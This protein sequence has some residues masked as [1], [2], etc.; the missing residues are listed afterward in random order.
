MLIATV[1]RPRQASSALSATHTQ[2]LGFPISNLA[3][4]VQI[5]LDRPHACPSAWFSQY[6]IAAVFDVYPRIRPIESTRNE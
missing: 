6:L 3:E 5:L 4:M 1:Y 2:H